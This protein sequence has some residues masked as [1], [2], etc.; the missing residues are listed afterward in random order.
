M[1]FVVLGTQKFQLNRLLQKLDEY[2]EQGLLKDEVFA[3]IGNSTYKPKNYKYKDFVDKKEFD[4]TVA[5]ADVVIAH[6]GVG[7]IIT[8]IHAQKPVIVYPRLAKYNEH[9]DDHQL[10]IAKAFEMKKYVLC[11]YENDDLLEKIEQSKS[12]HFDEYV[13]QQKQIIGIIKDFLET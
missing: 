6:S 5:K 9:V 7:T 11:C 2:V 12:Y 3:Q 13:S 1:I 4:E 8:A 10:D